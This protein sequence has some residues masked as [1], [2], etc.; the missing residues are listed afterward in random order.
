MQELWG[1]IDSLEWSRRF[2]SQDELNKERTRHAACSSP[3]ILARLR[4]EK[5]TRVLVFYL[6]Q[7]EG[8][9]QINQGTEG[10]QHRFGKYLG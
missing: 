1:A 3:L 4:K 9:A 5:S 6:P 10:V 8:E 7:V 2:M